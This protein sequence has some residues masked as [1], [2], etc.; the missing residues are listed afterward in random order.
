[1]T[2]PMVDGATPPARSGGSVIKPNIE[3]WAVPVLA[4]LGAELQ[5]ARERAGISLQQ[6]GPVVGSRSSLRDIER[7]RVRTRED[8][9]RPW[10]QFLG[11]DPEPVIERYA[12]V[13]APPREDGEVGW[14]PII[15]PAPR[16]GPARG[17]EPP[18][19]PAP[20]R[21]ALGAELWLLRVDAGLARPALAHRIGCSRVHIFLV[22]RGVRLPSPELTARW[23]DVVDAPTARIV[24]LHRR[25]PGRIAAPTRGHGA[26]GLTRTRTDGPDGAA[27]PRR[28]S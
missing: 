25:F 17:M 19:L 2:E 8:R 24:A 4:E 12:A 6:L 13:I 20:G 28:S 1:M 22:E 21:A 23:L 14:K 5:R 11:V 10:L 9:L 7:G 15:R 16:P 26:P 18:A 27:E 3:A